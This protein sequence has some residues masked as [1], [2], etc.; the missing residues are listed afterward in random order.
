MTNPTIKIHNV[1]TG[2]ESIVNL[3][4]EQVAEQRI[5]NEQFQ[6]KMA[7]REAEAQAKLEARKAVLA[8]LG[9]SDEEAAALLA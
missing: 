3:T 7:A 5:L 8:K 1:E 6:A 2:E 4:A 9:L